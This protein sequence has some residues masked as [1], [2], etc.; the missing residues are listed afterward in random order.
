MNNTI[1]AVVAVIGGI[2]GLAIVAVLVSN[3]AQTS[4][5]ISSAGSALSN[6][7]G[8]AVGPVTGNTSNTFG[9]SANVGLGT[10]QNLLR[11]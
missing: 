11:A 4:G 6:I 9:S 7:I 3:R 1:T 8:A 10:L 2:V 5:V